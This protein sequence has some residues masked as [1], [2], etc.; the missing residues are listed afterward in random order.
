MD[1][2]KV[3]YQHCCIQSLFED[4]QMDKFKLRKIDF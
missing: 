3:Y 4:K 2:N 1:R